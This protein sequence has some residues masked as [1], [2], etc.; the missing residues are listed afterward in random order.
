VLLNCVSGNIPSLMLTA[1]FGLS[2]AGQYARAYVLV[3]LPMG[4][5]GQAIGQ[6]F[7]ARSAA[8]KADGQDVSRLVEGVLDRLIGV[9]LLPVLAIAAIGPDIFV[10]FCGDRWAEAGVYSSILTPW[11]FLAAVYSPLSTL[12]NTFEIQGFGLVTNILL[13]AGRAAAL[14]I[15]GWVLHDARWTITLFMAVGVVLLAINLAYVLVVAGVA[16][17]H[18]GLSL[19]RHLLYALPTV[20]A[21]LAARFVLHLPS[22]LTVV[23]VTLVSFSYLV[24]VVRR[25]ELAKQYLAKALR[26]I[27]EMRRRQP[28]RYQPTRPPPPG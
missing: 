2:V 25:D 17:R 14:A 11:L 18:L 7:Y 21:G 13:V 5:I 22:W 12:I 6:V 1:A 23:I 28:S 27:K 10:V 3:L 19:V 24:L 20:V 16:L 9:S 8:K 15:G 4:I 26:R